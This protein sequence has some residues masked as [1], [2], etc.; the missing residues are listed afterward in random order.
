MSI[1]KELLKRYIALN[2]NISLQGCS[3]CELLMGVYQDI[4]DDSNRII[5]L[6]F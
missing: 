5:K 3:K 2:S 1:D 4:D 6:N